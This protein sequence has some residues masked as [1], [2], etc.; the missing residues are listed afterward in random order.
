MLP[1]ETPCREAWLRYLCSNKADPERRTIHFLVEDMTPDQI[2]Q[3]FE[4]ASQMYD[5]KKN[6]AV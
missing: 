4:I 5:G 1:C 2:H 3:L 6:M